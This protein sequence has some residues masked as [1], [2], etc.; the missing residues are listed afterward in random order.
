MKTVVIAIGFLTFLAMEALASFNGLDLRRLSSW[1]YGVINFL[2]GIVIGFGLTSNLIEGLK[3]G[4]LL[5]FLTLV[6]GVATR[7]HKQRYHGMA[8]SLLR[9]YGKEDNVSFFAKLLR[10]LLDK[11]K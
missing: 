11:Y 2:A 6:G 10:R 4:G 3:V 9:K 7:W 8:G 1:L 5:A